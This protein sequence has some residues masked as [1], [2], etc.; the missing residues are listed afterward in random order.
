MA[1]EE[2]ITT[3]LKQ[4]TMHTPILLTVYEPTLAMLVL[5]AW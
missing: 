4:K 1:G 3:R 2:A 5:G